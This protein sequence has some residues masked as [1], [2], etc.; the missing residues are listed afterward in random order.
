MEWIIIHKKVDKIYFFS[1]SHI[2]N[3]Y[4]IEYNFQPPKEAGPAELKNYPL[5]LKSYKYN[6]IHRTT[7][8]CWTD[9]LSG[10]IE[11]D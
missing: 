1:N 9:Y 2:T 11:T 3:Y 4:D 7:S 6:T 5:V 10:F 8:F